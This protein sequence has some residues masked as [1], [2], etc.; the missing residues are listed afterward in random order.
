M[1]FRPCIDI[2]NGQVKQIVGGTLRDQ[3]DQAVTNFAS[4]LDA[5]WYAKLYR[6][7]GLK[8]G[9]IILLNG[10]DSVYYGETRRQALLALKAYPGGM[11]VG[12]G[13]TAENGAAYLEA[14]A[15]HVIVTSYVFQDGKFHRGNLERLKA[16][17]GKERI[18]LDLSCRKK[19]GTYFIVT[20]RWQTFTDVAL[21]QDTLDFLSG[22]CDEFLIHGVD[23]EGTSAGA[24]AD[25]V[26]MLGSW[27]GMPVTYA[28][29]IGSME[30]LRRFQ[31]LS[32][33]GLDFTVGSALDLFGGDLPYDKISRL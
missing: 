9:H 20:N 11:Q 6:R 21:T 22:Y 30:E 23:V 16:A 27:R 24:E 3:G 12:G 26:R 8:G 15:S 17:V 1:K 25:L 10:V 32:G 31:E 4:Q 7:D 5:A 18:V 14:G 13:I 29:G 2:H 33:G 28:G 19:E